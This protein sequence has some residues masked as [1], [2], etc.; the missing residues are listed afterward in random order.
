MPARILQQI[1]HRASQQFGDTLHR[2]RRI[3]GVRRLGCA[4]IRIQVQRQLGADTGALFGGQP[5]QVDRLDGAQIGIARIQSA[6]QQNFFDQ[7]VQFGDVARNFKAR[8]RRRVAS[9]HFQAHAYARQR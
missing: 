8:C 4:P 5:N 6:G 1:A 2:Q 9:H 3:P 7:L